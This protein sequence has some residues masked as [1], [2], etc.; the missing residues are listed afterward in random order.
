VTLA[1]Q[2][3]KGAALSFPVIVCTQEL[4]F[5]QSSVATHVRVMTNPCGHPPPIVTSEKVTRGEASQ[6]SVA[7]AVPVLPGVVFPLH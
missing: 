4:E 6:L 1:G 3:I 7:V 2:L 5:P